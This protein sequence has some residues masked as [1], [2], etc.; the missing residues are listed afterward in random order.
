MKSINTNMRRWTF[1]TLLACALP[2]AAQ[3]APPFAG[4]GD[5]GRAGASRAAWKGGMG[6]E[7]GMMG[8]G[9][10]HMMPLM[11]L[12]LSEEQRDTL[13]ARMHAQAPRLREAA[14]ANAKAHDALRQLALSDNYDAAAARQLADEVARA[15]ADMSLLRAE[16]GAQ[17]RQVLTPEQRKQ[18]DA[19]QAG[20]GRM[21][22]GR[23]GG[24]CDPERAGGPHGRHFKG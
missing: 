22:A 16:M 15:E 20:G 2:L 8:P 4:N 11:S 9:M 3:A 10:R 24:M 6:G 1:A 14:K 7:G 21:A 23:G 17:M 18:F 13:F 12:G 5:C 19:Q